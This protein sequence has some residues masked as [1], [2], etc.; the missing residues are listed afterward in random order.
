VIR[1]TQT[2]ACL[3]ILL[4]AIASYGYAQSD[5]ADDA[6]APEAVAPVE[7]APS[8][9]PD[10]VPTLDKPGEDVL[11]P[12]E[13]VFR[14]T[15]NMAKAYSKMLL[16]NEF[17]QDIDPPLNPGQEER[18][19]NLFAK[20]LMKVGHRRSSEVGR[21]LETMYGSMISGQGSVTREQAPEFAKKA[22]KMT[23]AWKE[24]FKGAAQDCREFLNPS[25]LAAIEKLENEQLKMA[26]AFETKM[27]KWAD[28]EFGE[29]DDE[30]LN[31]FDIEVE[32][33]PHAGEPEQIR[34]ARRSAE[35]QVRSVG[36]TQ[37]QQWL[38]N[39][40]ATFKF[41]DEQIEQSEELLKNY[42]EQAEEIM[43]P[44][45]REKA[46]E[47]QTLSQLRYQLQNLAH[48]EEKAESIDK[49]FAQNLAPWHYQ[50]ESEFETMTKPVKDLGLKFRSEVLQLATEA[51]RRA[52]LADLLEFAAKHGMTEDE[53]RISL[54]PPSASGF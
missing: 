3:A 32:D 16:Q 2:K 35:W 18:V 53:Q 54:Q 51:Q 15:P 41:T 24:L 28:G 39:A 50:L 29:K 22:N 13:P 34:N 37:W 40:Q 23:P 49:E 12:T 43:T 52:A 48:D 33:D 26:N 42:R 25:Q 46:L 9:G 19:T 7:P 31:P 21:F 6:S 10:N 45:W 30:S 14:L 8:A 4:A 17:K 47:N 1:N 20:R 38:G 44:E 27:Q 5:T 11:K 36:P